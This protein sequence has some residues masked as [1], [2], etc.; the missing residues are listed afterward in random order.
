MHIDHS[1]IRYLMNKPLISSRVTRWLF[2]LQEFN[3]TII[4]RPGKYNVVADFLSRLNNIGEVTPINDDFLEKHLFSMSTDSPWFA[5]VANYLVTR[6]TPPHLYA[7]EKR[8]I[9]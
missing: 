9:V 6:K 5:N 4:D 1:A 7:C 2:L 3:I 8:N